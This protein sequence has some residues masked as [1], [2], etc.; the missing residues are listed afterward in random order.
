MD[1]CPAR[2]WLARATA[3]HGATYETMKR[4]REFSRAAFFVMLFFRD[5]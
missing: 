5:V 3:P 2:I 1:A 4:R